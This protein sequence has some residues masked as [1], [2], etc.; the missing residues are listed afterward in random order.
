MAKQ[1]AASSLDRQVTSRKETIMYVILFILLD[2]SKMLCSYALKY[3]N[4]DEYP[5]KQTLIVFS[6]ELLKLFLIAVQMINDNS[7]QNVSLTIL[8]ALPSIIYAVNNNLLLYAF[9]FTTP[10]VWSILTQ[11]RIIITA[12][13]YRILFKR[14]VTA[15]QWFALSLL[16]VAIVVTKISGDGGGI[17][18]A[19]MAFFIAAT[20]SVLSVTAAIF[21]EYL[22]KNNKRSFSEQQFQLYLY[23]SAFSLVFYSMEL[24]NSG[25]SVSNSHPST[26]ASSTSKSTIVPAMAGNLLPALL[27]A[28]VQLGAMSGLVTA[29][30]IKK[31]DNIVKIYSQSLTGI[32]NAVLSCV[33]FPRKF[34]PDLKYGIALFLVLV[35]IGL[36][37][38][39]TLRFTTDSSNNSS[40]GSSK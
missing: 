34:T 5:V 37:E 17:Y 36:Y 4:N 3:Y 11:S 40:D 21:M 27:L 25:S 15:L 16:C 20:V 29:T 32:L 22:F 39:K 10:A 26:A 31:L 7:I 1:P 33:L 6:T 8:F 28:T 2:L 18:I 38:R 30:V 13:V 12:C 19:P 24:Y 9:H 35:A 14:H 23:S